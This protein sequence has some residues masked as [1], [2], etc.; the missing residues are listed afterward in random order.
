[1]GGKEIGEN[2]RG[3]RAGK[4]EERAARRTKGKVMEVQEM[5]ELNF[6]PLRKFLRGRT[7]MN[8]SLS[9]YRCNVYDITPKLSAD[10]FCYYCWSVIVGTKDCAA[11]NQSIS[12]ASNHP[13]YSCSGD[14]GCR[15][16]SNYSRNINFHKLQ[17]CI[18]EDLCCSKSTKAQWKP[19]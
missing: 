7:P 6:A 16:S 3:G 14:S 4:R 8:V 1:M 12:Q 2:W 11:I 9:T 17:C 13:V 15:Y 19:T 18:C 10:R 5:E